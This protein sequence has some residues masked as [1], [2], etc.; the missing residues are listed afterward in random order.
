MSDK[1]EEKKILDEDLVFVDEESVK[2]KSKMADVSAAEDKN[3]KW[4]KTRRRTS[5]SMEIQRD[6]SIDFCRKYIHIIGIAVLVV[7]VAIAA[8][9][10]AV[11]KHSGPKGA[12]A[13]T[14]SSEQ[15]YELNEHKDINELIENYFTA[16]AAGDT[17]ELMNYAYPVTDKEK[18]YIKLYSEYVDKFENI[19]CY[20]KSGDDAGTYI[21]S[22]YTAVKFKDIKT[23]APGLYFFYVKTDDSGKVYIDN[24]YSAYNL[25]YQELEQDS[26]TSAMIGRYEETKDTQ[27]LISQTQAQYDKAVEKDADLKKLVEE[28]I[29]AAVSNWAQELEKDDTEAQQE[30]QKKQEEE[31][32]KQEEEKQKQEEE[33]KKQEAAKKEKAVNE[34]VYATDNINIRKSASTKAD[35]VGSALYGAEMTRVAVL[36]SGWSKVK[37]GNITGYV[38]SEFISTKKPAAKTGSLTPG[39]KIYLQDTVNVRSAMSEGSDRVGVAYSGETVTVVESYAQGWTKVNWNGK[40]GYIKTDVLAGM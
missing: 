13:V 19:N 38:K 32:K 16:Y 7:V 23:A 39:K 31:Q 40:V 14:E 8:I 28:T 37:T 15:S 18:S 11:K 21:V 29:P 6:K 30:E 34:K 4:K 17:D 22:V 35:T 12:P 1:K 25:N 36:D 20:T 9:V 10:V 26:E 27:D 5:D 3:V 24:V 2:D 33:Q